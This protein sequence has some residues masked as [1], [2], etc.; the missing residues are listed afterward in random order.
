MG[1]FHLFSDPD[2]TNNAENL[3]LSPRIRTP[4]RQ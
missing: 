2:R 4:I 1:P 3:L